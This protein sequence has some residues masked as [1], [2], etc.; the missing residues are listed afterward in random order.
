MPRTLRTIKLP[1]V[2]GR[3]ELRDA[4]SVVA[5]VHVVPVE[6]G[7]WTVRNTGTRRVHRHF[8]TQA[9]AID[10]ARKLSARRGKELII[11]GADGQIVREA[12]DRARDEPRGTRRA[13]AP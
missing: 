7:L 3:I 2:S 1:P 11:H 10:F 4:L 12:A 8:E 13:M 9:A 5:A 6:G